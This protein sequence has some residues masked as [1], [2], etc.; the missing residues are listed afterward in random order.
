MTLTKLTIALP[1]YNLE[2]TLSMSLDSI[3]KQNGN[4]DIE[5]LIVDN[6][7]TDGSWAI[8]TGYAQRYEN[9]RCVKNET[10]IGPDR[11]FLKCLEIAQGRYV[12]LL[13][14][15]LL[16]DGILQK[17]I[18]CVEE[19][20]DF[21]FLNYSPIIETEP[22]RTGKT[23][24]DFGG[25]TGP[26]IPENID[27]FFEKVGK[28]MTFLSSLV[29]NKERFDTIPHET[30]ESYINTYFLQT[31][32]AM[33][34]LKDSAKNI[35]IRDNCIAAG[36]NLSCGYDFYNVWFEQYRKLIFD[37]AQEIG[38]SAEVSDRLWKNQSANIRAIFYFRWK[39]KQ[40]KNWDRKCVFKNLKGYPW[41][42][43]KAAIAI[44]WPR[45][46]LPLMMVVRAVYR[47]IK[48][49]KH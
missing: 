7:S 21:I 40:S 49:R 1:C 36:P 5:I 15:D 33:L 22:L 19:N 32:L 11:N 3:L 27:E 17:I 47:K 38:V 46:L 45:F 44:Y 24:V 13:G 41:N 25:Q 14:D 20:P 23:Y 34:T 43:F 29:F 6:N 16:I 12:M 10:N 2:K 39:S 8:A 31:H 37:T 28:G 4:E 35:I 9:I 30:R 26:Y 48:R 42:Q 18:G